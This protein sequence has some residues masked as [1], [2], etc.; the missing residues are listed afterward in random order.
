MRDTEAEDVTRRVTVSRVP[1]LDI[2]SEDEEELEADHN[3]ITEDDSPES[4][5]SLISSSSWPTVPKEA[6]SLLLAS[7]LLLLLLLVTNKL[8]E[9]LHHDKNMNEAVILALAYALAPV[10]LTLEGVRLVVGSGTQVSST[11]RPVQ[12]DYD[13][14]VD[15][16][17]SSDKFHSV[18]DK[19]SSEKMALWGLEMEQRSQKDQ[20]HMT[21]MS[22]NIEDTKVFIQKE[23]EDAIS[24]I[25][26]DNSNKI[27]YENSQR[28]VLRVNLD[29]QISEFKQQIEELKNNIHKSGDERNKVASETLSKMREELKILEERQRLTSAEIQKCC[30]AKSDI[31]LVIENKVSG[32]VEQLKQDLQDKLV[33]EEELNLRLMQVETE[34]KNSFVELTSEVVEETK[35]ELEQLVNSKVEDLRRDLSSDLASDLETDG[36]NTR[37]S[38]GVDSVDVKRIVREALTKYD[39]DKTG[40]FDFA[41]ETAGGSVMTTKC[42][43]PYQ[44]TSAVMSVWGIPFWWDTNT[45]RYVTETVSPGQFE[46]SL[47]PVRNKFRTSFKA[48][49]N[50][51]QDDPAAG[52][53]SGSVLGLQRKSRG[54]CGPVVCQ[55]PHHR[56]HDRSVST[57]VI[58]TQPSCGGIQ[59]EKK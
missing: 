57:L 17:L 58:R 30:S 23:I 18:I 21:I 11:Q 4:E 31:D 37:D 32:L 39:A 49:L 20:D 45:P 22:S 28:E 40:L 27:Q 15:N 24:N 54:H 46:T 43:E 52:H 51:F 25:K 41:L 50:P 38:S 47:E 56:R 19:V 35:A 59:S 14:L 5:Q 26:S 9:T 12:I 53:L 8:V 55:H 33:T 6:R 1:R 48:A 3:N 7:L 36:N 16:I 34:N 29:T 10:R 42:T 13:L 44:M 2:Q